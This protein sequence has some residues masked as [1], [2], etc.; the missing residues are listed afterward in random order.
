MKIDVVLHSSDSN[1]FYLDFWPL[2]SKIWKTVFHMEP[3]LLYIDNDHT[4]PIDETYGKVIKLKP[5]DDI[6]LYLQCLWIRYWF[7]SQL[8][9]KVCMISDI[10]MFPLSKS[11]FINQL[12]K[13]PDNN[14]V[15]LNPD[16]S[17]LPS[18]YHVAKGSLFTKILDLEPTWEAS[19]RALHERNIGHDC[20]DG[21][22]P[23]LKGKLNWGADEEYATKKVR[24]YPDR[25]IIQFLPR[26][27]GRIDRSY[28]LY[29]P[30]DIRRD[31]YADSHSIRPYS[32][33]ENKTKIDELISY[34][35]R[36]CV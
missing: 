12:I 1:P 4:I 24:N 31:I 36:Y 17:F 29:S 10:D 8:P 32:D 7:P 11:Y 25:S 6:P 18:C 13:I 34:I 22:N 5:V 3:I 26:K 35:Y 9:D 28:W 20:F 23:I 33:P 16:Q 2:V 30:I 21:S 14:Y 15:H 19:I 27:Q